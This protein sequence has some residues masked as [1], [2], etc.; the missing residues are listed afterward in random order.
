MSIMHSETGSPKVIIEK[1]ELNG[2][3]RREFPRPK[4]LSPGEFRHFARSIPGVVRSFSSIQLHQASLGD[5][6]ALLR[7]EKKAWPEESR[8]SEEMLQS[9]IQI[10]SEGVIC[11][12][13]GNERIGFLCTEI[14]A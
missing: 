6:P 7:V 10:F 3:E 14:L 8:A 12:K 13:T 4:L 1:P 5:L 11:A 2:Q 9:R